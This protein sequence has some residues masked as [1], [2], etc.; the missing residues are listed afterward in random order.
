MSSP[1]LDEVDNTRPV[2]VR[3][4]AKDWCLIQYGEALG[5]VKQDTLETENALPVPSIPAGTQVACFNAVRSGWAGGDLLRICSAQ[6][7]VSR[8]TP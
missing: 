7:T 3:G 8:S 2:D 6:A 1:A 5:W 4:C